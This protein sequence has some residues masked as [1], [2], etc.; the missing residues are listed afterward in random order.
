MTSEI[1]NLSVKA[2]RVERGYTQEA[3]A[4]MLGVTTKHYRDWE[5]GMIPNKPIL[6]FAVAYLLKMDVD[7]LR[8]PEKE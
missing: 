5:N 2:A 6:L 1:N 8:V 3:L 7:L 4:Q